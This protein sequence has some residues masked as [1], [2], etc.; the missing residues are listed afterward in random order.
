VHGVKKRFQQLRVGERL[1]GM[2]GWVD[3]P[4]KGT[5]KRVFAE[6]EVFVGD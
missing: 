5:W 4:G 6:E 2:S 1:K 3:T